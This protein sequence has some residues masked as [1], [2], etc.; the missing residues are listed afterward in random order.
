MIY[1]FN[2][3][4]LKKISHSAFT[5]AEVLITLLIIGVVSSLVIPAIIQDTQDAE[6]KTAL[7]KTY[8]TLS[9]AYIN[10]LSDNA[11]SLKD[12]CSGGYSNSMCIK[13]LFTPYLNI[14]KSCTISSTEKCWH[15]AYK[16]FYINPNTGCGSYAGRLENCP[17]KTNDFPGYIL[18]D[19]ILITFMLLGGNCEETT[20]T[21]YKYCGHITF[22]VN[23]FKGPNTVGKDI[24]AI[25][26]S[27]NSIHP[28]G[29][30]D[31]YQGYCGA[32]AGTAN[33]YK[34]GWGCTAQRLK[35]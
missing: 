7:K 28:V 20:Y 2:Y 12:V 33:Y 8:S 21:N 29:Y 17:G 24:F 18:N 9:Q 31:V 23:G 15:S 1:L 26:I 4:K 13:N 30:N 5:L 14:T 6:L 11:G 25:W 3:K 19:G 16:W 32:D 10:I 34:A 27:S 22:D 35:E